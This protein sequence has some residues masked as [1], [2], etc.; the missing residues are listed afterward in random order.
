MFPANMLPAVKPSPPPA[1]PRPSSTA[2]HSAAYARRRRHLTIAGGVL[3]ALVIGLWLLRPWHQPPPE[4]S[5]TALV[6][7]TNTL[8]AAETYYAC[9][10]G[11]EPGEPVVLSRSGPTNGVIGPD[12]E[13]DQAGSVRL[14]PV[15]DRD[16]P[17]DYQIVA[18]GKRSDRTATA[19]LQALPSR[20][21]D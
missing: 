20:S 18:R 17:G 9:A 19:P 21:G 2:A 1:P 4:P 7:T 14:G 6:L 3:A 13:A 10:S 12:T 15:T 5:N 11:F 8:R 16:L